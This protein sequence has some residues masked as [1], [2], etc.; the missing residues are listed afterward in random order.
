M[1]SHQRNHDAQATKLQQT[2]KQRTG[3]LE[4]RSARPKRTSRRSVESCSIADRLTRHEKPMEGS[5][6]AND[7]ASDAPGMI[8]RS[9]QM[10]TFAE[11][12][13]PCNPPRCDPH[14]AS[15]LKNPQ[16]RK[17]LPVGQHERLRFEQR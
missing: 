16:C 6:N 15:A 12:A 8:K 2:E 9:T 3:G 11:S 17:I 1:N 13:P 5:E 14:N 7:S 10:R 4:T